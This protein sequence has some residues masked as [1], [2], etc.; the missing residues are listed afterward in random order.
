M[1][2]VIIKNVLDGNE[3]VLPSVSGLKYKVYDV[4]MY[5]RNTAAGTSTGH[6]FVFTDENTKVENG[7]ACLLLP[8]EANIGKVEL[9]DLQIVT[10]SGSA[11][12]TAAAGGG[13]G[14]P[15]GNAMLVI[16]Y[17]ELAG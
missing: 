1:K 13:V 12:K 14:L 10:A 11:I 5:N 7:F 6:K 8:S 16:T 15:D 9:F 3:I 4:Y 17:E 2:R